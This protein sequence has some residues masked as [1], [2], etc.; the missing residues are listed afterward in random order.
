MW[1]AALVM[2]YQC[3]V[4]GEPFKESRMVSGNWP[5]RGG[6]ATGAGIVIPALHA[7]SIEVRNMANRDVRYAAEIDRQAFSHCGPVEEQLLAIS[8]M[9]DYQIRVAIVDGGVPVGYCAIGMYR[10]AYEI[11]RIAVLPDLQRR[12]IGRIL[13]DDV[14]ARLHGQKKNRRKLIVAGVPE[15]DLATQL[16]FRSCGFRCNGEIP[17]QMCE[18]SHSMLVMEFNVLGWVRERRVLLKGGK[19]AGGA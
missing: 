2:T 13:I 3:G 17:C 5:S 19:E 11:T 4:G 8:Q 6:G 9:R 1:T 18:E 16:F 15:E 12:G 10:E 14:R 7:F